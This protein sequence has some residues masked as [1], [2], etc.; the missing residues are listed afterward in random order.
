[1]TAIDK[2]YVWIVHSREEYTAFQNIIDRGGF[3]ITLINNNDAGYM[4]QARLTE[5]EYAL[6]KL[7]TTAR[8]VSI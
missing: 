4:Y 2:T 5:E 6:L 7:S 8:F 1:M 3:D